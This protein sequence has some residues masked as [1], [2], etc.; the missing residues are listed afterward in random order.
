MRSVLSF[1]PDEKKR[2][3]SAVC[4][5]T[6]EP[7]PGELTGLVG[8]LLPELPWLVSAVDRAQHNKIDLGFGKIP[9]ITPEDL[10]ISKSYALENSPDRFQDLDDLKQI[11]EN[12]ED[13]DFDYLREAMSEIGVEIPK[14][15]KKYYR[16]KRKK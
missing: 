16:K 15:V 3:R 12:R 9:V 11:L 6:S 14:P 4:M 2:K 13:L 10:I 7:A 1:T 8:I 5:V